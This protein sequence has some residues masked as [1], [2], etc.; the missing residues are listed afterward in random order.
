MP[1]TSHDQNAHSFTVSAMAK[2]EHLPA[3]PLV[4]VTPHT[5]TLRGS[6]LFLRYS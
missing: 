5:G 1:L 4:A 6:Y 3:T 2:L